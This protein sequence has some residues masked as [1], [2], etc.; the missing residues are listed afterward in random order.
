LG[1]KLKCPKK[2]NK[3]PA[4]ELPDAGIAYKPEQTSQRSFM[5]K[6]VEVAISA[7]K[8]IDQI[9]E[10][11][12]GDGK[13]CFD[14]VEDMT[15]ALQEPELQ[16]GEEEMGPE[17]NMTKVN[18]PH[19]PRKTTNTRK[20]EKK[21]KAK[22][23]MATK[24]EQQQ[25]LVDDFERIPEISN[26]VDQMCKQREE[27]SKKRKEKRERESPYKTHIIYSNRYMPLF[28]EVILPDQVPSSLRT[29]PN[30]VANPLA[31]RYDNFLKRNLVVPP[32]TSTLRDVP[33]VHRKLRTY[34]RTSK[35]MEGVE[36]RTMYE[37]N[38]WV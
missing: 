9:T 26:E 18:L 10:S 36:G 4:V 8:E 34:E 24:Q 12:K 32:Y 1:T 16:E 22:K 38:Y 2:P 30:V 17:P 29:L 3:I 20:R 7:Q 15:K 33:A 6:A 31:E 11:L 13:P 14:W 19:V 35:Q 21:R 23:V 25:H 28:P 5:E 37:V 27:N